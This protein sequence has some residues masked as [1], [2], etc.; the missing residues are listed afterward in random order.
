MRF[1]DAALAALESIAQMPDAGSPR[2]GEPCDVPGLRAQRVSRFPCA[3][4]Y[5][6][7][8]DHVDVVRL[9]ADA[10]DLPAILGQSDP[11]ED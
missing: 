1:F 4:Y 6:V 5:F 2:A 7:A 11:T 3:W 9:L 8:A 10:H